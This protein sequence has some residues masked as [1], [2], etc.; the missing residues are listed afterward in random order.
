MLFN[1]PEPAFRVDPIEARAGFVTFLEKA[2]FFGTIFLLPIGGSDSSDR[3]LFFGAAFFG[4]LDAASDPDESPS[5]RKVAAI[6]AASYPLAH[7]YGQS[8]VK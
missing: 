8:Y 1:V 2:A 3:R 4:E 5:E 6:F 7:T